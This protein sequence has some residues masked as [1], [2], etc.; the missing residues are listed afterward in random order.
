MKTGITLSI[1]FITAL[2]LAGCD[3]GGE[4]AHLAKDV[5]QPEAAARSAANDNEAND[6][7]ALYERSFVHDGVLRSYLLYVPA[8][9]D[10]EDDWPLVINYHGFAINADVQMAYTQMNA[11]ADEGHFLV[12]YPQGLTVVNQTRGPG[13]GWSVPGGIATAEHDDVGFTSALIDHVDVDFSIDLARVHATGWSNGSVMSL[14][15]ACSLPDRIASVGG[16]A[17]PM[18]E[19]LT[20]ICEPDRPFSVLFLHGTADPLIPY[21]GRPGAFP[22]APETPSFW[23]EQN[24][25]SPNPLSEDIDDVV[26]DDNST[27]TRF[28]YV[29]CDDDTEVWFYR[30]NNGGHPWP[31]S[32]PVPGWEFLGPTNQDISASTE[33]WDFFA[34]NPH[35]MANNERVQ[36]CHAPPGNPANAR[37]IT[38]SINALPAHLA[39]GDTEGPCGESS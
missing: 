38:V 27:V 24:S 34:R 18:T 23:A 17:G 36:V 35:P 3:Q 21:A 19:Q 4:L 32:A 10:G 29:N 8:V 39:H 1:L 12:A 26:T 28:E 9:Y 30:I 25:C 2:C 22:P 7:G 33:V 13:P 16:V 20:D 14:Y 6:P 37:T 11:V 31:G 15:L 5:S